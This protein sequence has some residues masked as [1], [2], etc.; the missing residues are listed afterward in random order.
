MS[1]ST[2]DIM[3]RVRFGCLHRE[4]QPHLGDTWADA[5]V[6]TKLTVTDVDQSRL[7]DNP[8]ICD[9]EEHFCD[10]WDSL[11]NHSTSLFPRLVRWTLYPTP[12]ILS[13]YGTTCSDP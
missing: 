8:S 5:A 3:P 4:N 11:R 12:A 10:C 9:S 7:G 2:T 13:Q 1:A 6:S